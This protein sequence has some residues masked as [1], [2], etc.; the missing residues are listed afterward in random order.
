MVELEA[1]EVVEVVLG[2]ATSDLGT[3][4]GGL[5]L[6]NNIILGESSLDVLG[7]RSA[8][9]VEAEGGE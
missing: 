3:P 2:V 4:C 5:P 1:L 7:A 9:E 6:G 8:V